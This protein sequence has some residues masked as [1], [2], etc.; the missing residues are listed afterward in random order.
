MGL[1]FATPEP[2]S[3]APG[4]RATPAAP[5]LDT[6]I[7]D[8]LL[9]CDA[10]RAAG[11]VPD[12]IASSPSVS[13]PNDSYRS[14]R[15]LALARACLDRLHRRWPWTGEPAE[16]S[17]PEGPLAGLN[18]TLGRYTLLNL[19]G[20]GGHGLVFLAKDPTL[21]RK[22]ALKIPRPE[23]LASERHRGRFLREARALARLD[24]PGIVPIYDFGESG[25]VCYLATAYI[26]GPSL[27]EWLARQPKH[28]GPD[29]AA[30][31]LLSMAE[32][33]AHA[34]SRGVLH[35]DLKPGNVLM[36]WCDDPVARTPRITDFGLAKLLDETRD[37]ARTETLPFGTPRYMSPEQAASDRSRIGPAAD[38]YGLGAILRTILAG[39]E[40]NRP[41]DTKRADAVS[42]RELP[43]ALC[44]ILARCLE[45][46]PQDRYPT[47]AALAED[48]RRFAA[49]QSV[50]APR[51]GRGK[52]RR[53]WDELKVANRV[54]IAC[55][56]LL[57]GSLAVSGL[58]L[59]ARM[60]FPHVNRAAQPTRTEAPATSP[61][62][63]A[64]ALREERYTREMQSAY[65]LIRDKQET[66]TA[67]SERLDRWAG[68]F[69]S[70]EPDPRGFEW[71]YLKNFGH[72]EWLTLRHGEQ[73]DGKPSAVYH[74]RFSPDGS[75]LVTAGKDGTARV[76]DAAGGR[77]LQVL[78]HK[79]TEVNSAAFSP[80]GK[81]VATASDDGF[82]RLWDVASCAVKRRFSPP[83]TDEAYAALFTPDGKRLVSA[84]R[85]GRLVVWSASTGEE[86]WR[87]DAEVGA[88]EA[89]AISSDGSFAAAGGTRDGRIAILNLA[90][91]SLYW[92]MRSG[93]GIVGLNI[94]PDNRWIAVNSFSDVVLVDLT[95]RSPE[96][97]LSGHHGGV[98]S[99]AFA[100]DR[101][102]LA[103][104]SGGDD[105]SLKI[106]EPVTG[107]LRDVLP[108]HRGAN[109]FVTVSPDSKRLA[110]ASADG[111]A[112]LWELNR[113]TD[114]TTIHLPEGTIPL[115]IA[116]SF[117]SKSVKEVGIGSLKLVAI[118]KDGTFIALDGDDGH[119]L[120][121][122]SLFPKPIVAARIAPLARSI[123]GVSADG[124][125]VIADVGGDRAPLTVADERVTT[126]PSGF[127]F[128][129]TGRG[130][131]CAA[132]QGTKHEHGPHD[133]WTYQLHGLDRDRDSHRPRRFQ[134]A[135]SFRRVYNS[136][137]H[138]FRGRPAAGCPPCI[139]GRRNRRVGFCRRF[140]TRYAAAVDRSPNL[141]V[142]G[143]FRRKAHRK[144]R[145]R[146]P[147]TVTRRRNAITQVGVAQ[148]SR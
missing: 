38:V 142:R 65:R 25:S 36:D 124:V 17:S 42:R 108:G 55:V 63:V 33:I 82:V 136:Q 84:S 93:S 21:R 6:W 122:R 101:S 100:P 14:A 3:S 94:A 127:A 92:R 12:D 22:V 44:Q 77:C 146:R 57:V 40:L 88:V 121:A 107:R 68:P 95:S 103:S 76:W 18:L 74:V 27:A 48:L 59:S 49:G 144:R 37:E 60:P 104:V 66:G 126:D 26:D 1:E 71:G 54:F 99:V 16:D 52:L 130:S 15:E 141:G 137:L 4:G 50:I 56:L 10:A 47:A 19:I 138:F 115:D 62:A 133:G 110:T 85:D 73:P 112:K 134:A 128:N 79:G 91:Y 140:H 97:R 132:S 58:V 102:V 96:N 31:L 89:L 117:E 123:A 125:L 143:L 120:E 43:E 139:W 67:D 64:S 81:S 53:A 61:A 105:H 41:I 145:R 20:S 78:D 131:C 116:V 8:V 69:S 109:Y 111:T 9:A 5:G 13:S 32:A 35:L 80:D 34:H 148:S 45:R 72:R 90:D 7:G 119:T 129:R 2:T 106:W 24:H 39:A 11:I 87:R 147:D 30:R 51:L 28:P 29:L 75:R 83:H 46:S 114:R 113:R 135:R 98:E 118:A 86:L 70:R 23:W